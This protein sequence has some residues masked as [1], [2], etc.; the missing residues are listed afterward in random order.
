MPMIKTLGKLDKELFSEEYGDLQ[1]DEVIITNERFAHIN[2]HH[3]E[4]VFYFK[5]YASEIITNPDYVIDDVKNIGTVFMIK[6]IPGNSVNIVIRLALGE[7]NAELKN[8]VLTCYRLRE[9]N[10]K[11]LIKK[12]KLLYKNI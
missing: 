10:L 8:S 11:K 4:D 3:P 2:K 5:K 1:T 6:M 9:K 12:N 7:D